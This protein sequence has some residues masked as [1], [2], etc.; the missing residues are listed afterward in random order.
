MRH[1][2]S[3]RLS[4]RNVLIAA[5][6]AAA[7]CVGSALAEPV[8]ADQQPHGD[9]RSADEVA[10]GNVAASPPSADDAVALRGCA[11]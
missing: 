4:Y 3:S 11:S 5:G 2:A 1:R 6:L 10:G 9:G 7:L 8:A